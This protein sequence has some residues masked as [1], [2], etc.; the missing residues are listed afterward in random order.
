MEEEL[1]N[2]EVE[3]VKEIIVDDAPS[4]P[5]VLEPV[6]KTKKVRSQKQIEALEKAKIK[7][8]ENIALKKKEKV[9]L[10]TQQKIDKLKTQ[11]TEEPT[12]VSIIDKLPVNEKEQLRAQA[13]NKK[14]PKFKPHDWHDW[15]SHP[16]PI[17][18]NYY[19]SGQTPPPPVDQRTSV[20]T[21]LKENKKVTLKETSSEEEEDVYTE[22]EVDDL[23]YQQPPQQQ[24]KYKF[25]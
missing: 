25:V 12:A 22:E 11:I 14:E 19:Y 23:V 1:E 9:T 7:R 20:P 4:D 3:R 24:L 8:A 13:I 5:A 16:A 15:R 18:N 2:K 21:I 6:K 10:K 17:I